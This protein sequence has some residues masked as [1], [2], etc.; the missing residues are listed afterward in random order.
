MP[1]LPHGA[2]G[3]FNCSSGGIIQ[4]SY[5]ADDYAYVQNKTAMQMVEIV[6]P[7]AAVD[8]TPSNVFQ[9]DQNNYKVRFKLEQ[10]IAGELDGDAQEAEV[11]KYLGTDSTLYFKM[12]INL[13]K[14]GEDFYEYIGSYVAISNKT[15]CWRNSHLPWDPN[16]SMDL[17]TLSLSAERTRFH[18]GPGSTSG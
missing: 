1:R 7:Y 10:E 9:L 6:D 8:Q 2:S 4:V 11:M 12:K 16:T 3:R 15:W 5:E 14:P 18:S 13:R 17:F